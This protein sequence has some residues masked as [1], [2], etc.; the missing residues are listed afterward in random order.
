M[1]FKTVGFLFLSFVTV[2]SDVLNAAEGTKEHGHKTPHGGIVKEA[3][4]M[5]VEFLIDK[6]GEPKLYLYD[7][8]MKPLDRTDMQTKLTVKGHD[9]SQ[10]SRELKASKDPKEGVVFKGEPVKGL[11]DWDTAVVS[12][13]IKDRWTH[14]RFSHH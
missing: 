10:H 14:I 4:G 8:A 9:G 2:F 3:E 1:Y 5:H 12:L 11:S 7:K 6:I 13:K